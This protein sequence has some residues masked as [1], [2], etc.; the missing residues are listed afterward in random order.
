[1]PLIENFSEIAQRTRVKKI[2]QR[3][4]ERGITYTMSDDGMLIHLPL[5]VPR[6][7]LLE[8]GYTADQPPKEK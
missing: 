6:D 7:I 8:A 3:C 4:D 1:M 2:Q 5:D